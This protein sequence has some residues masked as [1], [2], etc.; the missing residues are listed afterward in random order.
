[1]L[2]ELCGRIIPYLI[3]WEFSLKTLFM[4]GTN[5]L[6]SDTE[7]SEFILFFYIAYYLMNNLLL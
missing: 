6:H 4:F 7:L 5:K 1:M 2:C 3:D